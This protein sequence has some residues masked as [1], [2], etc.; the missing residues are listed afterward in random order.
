MTITIG[1]TT[2]CHGQTRSTAGDAVGPDGLE[3]EDVPGVAVYELIGAD[4]IAPEHVKCDAGTVSFSVTRTFADVP[5][6]LAYFEEGLL[7]EAAEGQ[8]KFGTANVFGPKS[9]VTRRRAK[10][11]GCSVIVSY[12]IQG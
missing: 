6:A 7:E 1:S 8:L 4:R 5:A 12:N 2:L 3:I 11:V 10:L 9:V